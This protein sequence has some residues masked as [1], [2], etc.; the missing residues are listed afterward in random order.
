M[1]LGIAH[2]VANSEMDNF[3]VSNFLVDNSE[4]IQSVARARFYSAYGG[5]ATYK[6]YDRIK[7]GQKS[8]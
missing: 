6:V 4:Y 8:G 7:K 2:L 5:G 3:L 1:N